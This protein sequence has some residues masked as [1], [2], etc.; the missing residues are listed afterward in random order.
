LICRSHQ[1]SSPQSDPDAGWQSIDWAPYL[2]DA[3]IRGN[4][5]RYA[6]IGSG[7]PILLIH[8]LGGSWQWWLRVMPTLATKNRVIAVDLPGFGESELPAASGDLFREQVMTVGGLLDQLRI[9]KALV[10]GHSMGGLVALQFTCDHPARVSGLLLADAGGANIAPER[11]RWILLGFRLF[12]AAFSVP[13]V[14]L[15]VA[16]TS[17]LRAILLWTAVCDRRS[18]TRDLALQILP[19][20]AASG[21]MP[22]VESAAAALNRVTPQSVT[23]PC[24]V[25]WGDQ[26]RILPLP[27]G[28][29]LASKLG[30]ARFV[31]FEGVGHCPMIE[32]PDEFTQLLVDFALDPRAGRPAG[33][34]LTTPPTG[35]QARR[36]WRPRT[37][38]A[39]PITEGELQ[40]TQFNCQAI[41]LRADEA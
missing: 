7:T 26:D 6:D 38:S 11:L 15:L 25:V 1:Q 35:R 18:V 2:H 31:P 21:F 12:G 9:A 37:A 30:D 36:G 10:V 8:G 33:A 4:H 22:S 41:E 39:S 19:G 24:L 16:R 13:W 20:M 40:V 28:Q 29:S 23:S 34:N 27:T 3:T 17:W 14:P 32:V 5:V